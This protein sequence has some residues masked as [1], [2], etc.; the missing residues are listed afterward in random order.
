MPGVGN[1]LAL[2]LRSESEE[3]ARFRRGQ[4]FGSSCR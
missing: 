4:D 3:S 2:V 1:I